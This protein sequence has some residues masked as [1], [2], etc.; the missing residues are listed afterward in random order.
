MAARREGQ[1]MDRPEPG[2]VLR[3]GWC[4]TILVLILFTALA[5]CMSAGNTSPV[6]PGSGTADTGQ[7]AQLLYQNVV[8][9]DRAGTN[10]T[11]EDLRAA[12]LR[13]AMDSDD[14][15][16]RDF[17]VSLIAKDHGGRFRMSQICDLWDAVYSRWTYV[18]DPGGGDYFSPAS[19]TIALDLKGDCDDFAILIAAM[20]GSVGGDARV[21]V[22]QN[23]TAGHVYPEVFVGTTVEEFGRAAAYIRGRYHVTEIGCHVTRDAGGTRYWLNLD[24][25]SSHPGGRFFADDGTRIAYYPDGRWERVVS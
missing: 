14:P 21:V 11:T 22:A 10:G 23:G 25:W 15:V 18:E 17:T 16:T 6:P 13:D 24:W 20:I 2:C 8:S 9:T 5:G 7:P 4:R 19:R 1:P 3:I 12:V